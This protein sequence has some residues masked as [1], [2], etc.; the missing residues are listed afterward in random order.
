[1]PELVAHHGDLVA[2]HELL[3]AGYSARSI[4]AATRRGELWRVR[5]GWFVAPGT[6]RDLMAGARVGGITSCVSALRMSGVWAPPDDGR[7]HVSVPTNACQLRTIGDPRRRITES[8][9]SAVIHWNSESSVHRLVVDPIHALKDAVGCQEPRFAFAMASSLLRRTPRLTQR[10]NS[11]I[12]V[13]PRRIRRRLR[14]VDTVCES[15]TES[16]FWWHFCDRGLTIRRQVWIGHKRVDFLIG[17]RLVI[18]IDSKEYHQDPERFEAD[19]RRDAYL[20]RLGYRVLRFSYV[21]VMYQWDDVE[22]AVLA[23]VFRGDHLPA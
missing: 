1:M 8:D 21:Q 22:A 14:F 3:A 15:G 19:R 9:D 10:W 6:P 20:S 7:V 13:A 4:Q 12:E 17:E 11:V 2:T 16:I 23:A 18:E 5:Q